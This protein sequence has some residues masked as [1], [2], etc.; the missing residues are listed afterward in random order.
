M[1]TRKQ[2][3]IMTSLLLIM[4]MVLGVYAA[5]YPYRADD[6]K[7]AFDEA[8]AERASIVFARNCRLCHGDVGEGGA[9][10]AR[11]PAAPALHRADLMGF[12]DSEGKLT[13]D[14]DAAATTL[15]LDNVAKFKGGMT[16]IV[17]DEWMEIKGINNK[18][19]TVKRGAGYTKA[20][21]HSKDAGVSFRDPAVLK[22]KIKLMTN[23][24]TCGRVGTPMPPWGQS[25]GGPLSDEQIRQIT[26]LITQSRWDL[27][28]EEV[29]TEDRL[30]VHLTEPMDDTT[31]TMRVTDV[32][33]FSAK[34]AIRIGDERLR[35][36]AVPNPPGGKKTWAEVP[37]KDRGGIVEVQRGVLGS[38]PL[39]HTP[40]DEIFKFPEVATP[41][42]TASSC[43]QFAQAPAP[44]GTP[45]TIPDPF[46]GQSVEIVAT[47]LAFD[48]KELTAKSGGKIRVRLDNKDAGVE[49]NIAFYKSA[50]E[51]Q[52]VSPG[53]VGIRFLGP[54]TGDTAF[55]VPAAGKYFFRCDV[56]PQTMTGTFTVS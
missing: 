10:G 24:I 8:T 37:V 33:V 19:L 28:K 49:H 22:D 17:G 21:A 47:N 4:L 55:D 46:D 48:K 52:A 1:N 41:A 20:E 34:D 25:Q 39:E 6:A 18:T 30:T 43:G 23:T 9:L 50:N 15:E 53:S 29:D 3:L 16:I 11:L 32:A 12:V 51:T 42:I 45:V 26:V 27:V 31:I 38:T 35:I 36:T 5:W 40:E 44:A 14:I 13:K 56:H 54:G 7:V 2:V